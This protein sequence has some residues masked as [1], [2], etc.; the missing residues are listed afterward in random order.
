MS[1]Q[2]NT[3]SR[4]RRLTALQIDRAKPTKKRQEI[5]DGALLGLYLVIQPSGRKGWCVRYR[6]QCDGKPRKLTLDGF[7]SLAVAHK[8][9][10][11]ALDEVAAGGD[12]AADKQARPRVAPERVDIVDTV[13]RDFLTKHIR[14][15]DGR[16]MRES[17][18]VETARLLG[19]RRDDDGV[20]VPTGAGVLAH[21]RGRTLQSIRR[22]D[23]L[24]LLD[25]L[26]PRGPVTANR[27]LSALR[28]LFKWHMQRDESLARS[29]CEGVP[30]PSPEISRERVL[31][32]QELAALWHAAE[33][34]G[35]AF[36]SMVQLLI[37]TGTRRDEARD[38]V[39]SE[40]SDNKRQW[41]IPGD[42]TKNHRDHLLPLPDAAIIMLNA[43]PRFK[44]GDFLF[45]TTGARPITGL[46]RQEAASRCHH[47]RAWH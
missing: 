47:A 28:T 21:W 22:R 30:D 12:P 37:L 14:R 45:T 19:L 17:T 25:I 43:L 36:G 16:P 5:P 41:L 11:E 46:A 44:G 26:V 29:P 18:K 4:R 20:W 31:S 15:K 24:D 35:T 7:P 39:W 6:R 13:F 23:V 1:H 10:R 33:A 8:L 40:F 27:T 32:D 42:R 34:D 38:A 3:R 9:A 2:C